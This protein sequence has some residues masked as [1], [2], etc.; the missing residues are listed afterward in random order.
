MLRD[1]IR[2][3]DEILFY[4]SSTK[5]LAVIGTAVVVKNGYPDFT[6]WDPK[7]EHPDAKSTPDNPIWYMVDIRATTRFLRPVTR[8]MLRAAPELKDMMVL[9]RG[10]RLSIQP[11]TEGEWEAVVRMGNAVG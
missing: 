9:R 3:G 7:S 1:D 5:P 8:D 2:E 11:V 6:A 4:H 10:A